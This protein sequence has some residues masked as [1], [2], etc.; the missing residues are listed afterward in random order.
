[1]TRSSTTHE[2]R[3]LRLDRPFVLVLQ[4][5]LSA[6]RRIPCDERADWRDIA[7]REGFDF[8]SA[9]DSDYWDERA[10]YAFTLEQIERDLEAP[11]AELDA[12]VPRAGQ[13]APSATSA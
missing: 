13:R 11:T 3:R 12:H 2:Q 9:D 10:Y 7:V 5:Q 8:H 1:M 4:R 6:M